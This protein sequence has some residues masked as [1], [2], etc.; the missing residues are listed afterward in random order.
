MTKIHVVCTRKQTITSYGDGIQLIDS[1]FKKNT[2]MFLW[3]KKKFKK[4]QKPHKTSI[5]LMHQK[6][7]V[8]QWL[9]ARRFFFLPVM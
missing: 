2:L 4:Q 9:Q 1:C 3:R 7:A 6:G 5:K 8:L